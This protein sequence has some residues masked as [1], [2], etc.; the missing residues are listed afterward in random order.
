MKAHY[1]AFARYNAWANRRLYD[2]AAEL[3]DEEY[4]AEIGRAHV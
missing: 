2:A 3:S 1:A 4:R